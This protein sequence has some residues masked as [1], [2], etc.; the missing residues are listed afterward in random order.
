MFA[1]ARPLAGAM[2]IALFIPLFGSFARD[3]ATHCCCRMLTSST[4]PMRAHRQ[5]GCRG[6]RS[7][8]IGGGHDSAASAA[9]VPNLLRQPALLLQRH[10]W[11]PAP[12]AVSE[13]LSAIT[14]PGEIV[15]VPPDPPPPRRV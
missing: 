11:Q 3:S 8:S 12:P 7:C 9:A 10:A 5:A 1:V 14:G 2:I 15:L 13:F 4:C 6:T